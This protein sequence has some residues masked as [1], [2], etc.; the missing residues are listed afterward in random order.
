MSSRIIL[1]QK[2]ANPTVKHNIDSWS[3][4]ASIIHAYGSA[5]AHDL[6]AAVSQH[7]HPAGGMAFIR[8]CIRNKWLAE[9]GQSQQ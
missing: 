3:V 9:S 2:S 7:R 6:A 4:V 8:Y 1:G 5:T